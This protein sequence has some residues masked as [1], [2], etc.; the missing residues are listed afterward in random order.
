MDLPVDKATAV[1]RAAKARVGQTKEPFK[2]M[3]FV[4]EI[5]R[6]VGVIIPPI[7]PHL[8]PPRTFNISVSE[9]SAPPV[10]H[11]MFLRR[12][13]SES[14]RT[15][16]HVVIV[17]ENKTVIHCSRFISTKVVESSLDSILTFYEFA[18]SI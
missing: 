16:T 8:P 9:V 13:D 4:R 1:L 15:W 12:K 6:E 11:V 18:H 14:K 7:S 2:C 5:Y 17:G 3:E 10:G